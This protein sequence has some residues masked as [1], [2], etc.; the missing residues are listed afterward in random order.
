MP[1]VID[2]RQMMRDTLWHPVSFIRRELFDRYGGYDT[3]FRICGDYDWF[4][5]VIVDKRVTT[6]HIQ[7]VVSVFDL[8]GVSSRPENA[9]VRAGEKERA[10]RKW[11]T[12]SQIERFWRWENRRSKA[13]SL[14]CRLRRGAHLLVDRHGAGGFDRYF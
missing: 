1:D 6:R 8:T 11:L 2:L 7:L 12:E 10:R 4:F 14:V 5:N 3:S 13:A 9:G